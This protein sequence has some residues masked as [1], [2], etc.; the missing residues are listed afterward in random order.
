M[1][2]DSRE[3]MRT[4]RGMSYTGTT[5]RNAQANT[6][7]ADKRSCAWQAAAASTSSP[8]RPCTTAAA[9][10]D[11]RTKFSAAIA[12]SNTCQQ[13]TAYDGISPDCRALP[14]VSHAGRKKVILRCVDI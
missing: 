6:Y 14:W 1:T 8:A 2:L 3:S 10:N 4:M 12:Q 13:A 11:H 5:D 7:P 9:D